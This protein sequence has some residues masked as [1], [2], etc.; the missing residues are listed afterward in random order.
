VPA[1]WTSSS[2]GHY[3]AA[4]KHT[5][6]AVATCRSTAGVGRPE[7]LGR[8]AG[9]TVPDRG[10]KADPAMCDKFS[11]FPFPFIIPKIR[12]NFKINGNK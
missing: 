10:P 6:G 7:R 12:I 8:W 4:D 2:V 1:A 3:R 9:P 5:L 11:Y